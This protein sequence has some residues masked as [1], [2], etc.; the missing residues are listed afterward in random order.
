MHQNLGNATVFLSES[1]EEIVRKHGL[2]Q[3]RTVHYM[4]LRE[5]FDELDSRQ[6]IDITQSIPG[7][8]SVPIMAL[9]VAMYMG[10]KDII[11]IGV[12]HDELRSGQYKYAFEPKAMHAKDSSVDLNGNV[13]LRNYDMFQIYAMLWRQY[14]IL[15][16]V[17]A[18]N[19]IHI[20]NATPG[21]ELDEFS[22]REF[23]TL[24]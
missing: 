6:I 2:F 11:L 19:N 13:L 20:I 4:A 22:R 15:S 14:R 18:A 1:E 9:M 12:D 24:F 5:D 16:E 7:V 17:A 3:G 8:M 23:D 10:F 21:G